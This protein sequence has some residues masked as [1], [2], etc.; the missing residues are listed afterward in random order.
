MLFNIPLNGL[1]DGIENPKTFTKSGGGT[2]LG[3]ALNIS[4]GLQGDP[5]H[6]LTG[7]AGQAGRVG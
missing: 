7:R 1:D 3:G 5:V 6:Y 4:E 2:K